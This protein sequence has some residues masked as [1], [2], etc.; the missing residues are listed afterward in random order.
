[1]ADIIAEAKVATD[2]L[3][4]KVEPHME[5][6]LALMSLGDF[7]PI[8]LEVLD[9]LHTFQAGEPRIFQQYKSTCDKL[10]EAIQTNEISSGQIAWKDV[11]VEGEKWSDH[12]KKLQL[13]IKT[14][15]VQAIQKKI[16]TPL[17]PYE[18]QPPGYEA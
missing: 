17:P 6:V 10:I 11:T 4:K 2:S 7:L 15:Q 16:E 5:G 18:A 9:T 12:L 1:M 8:A 14:L 3:L 13:Y